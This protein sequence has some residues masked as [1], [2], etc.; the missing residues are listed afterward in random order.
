MNIAVLQMEQ[1]RGRPPQPQHDRHRC[2]Q[3]VHPGKGNTAGKLVALVTEFAVKPLSRALDV[4]ADR[5]GVQ[6][7]AD[8]QHVLEGQRSCRTT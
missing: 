6:L 2:V 4:R 5:P 8:G 3:R 7:V 1:A